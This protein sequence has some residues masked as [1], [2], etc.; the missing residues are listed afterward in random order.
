MTLDEYKKRCAD[1]LAAPRSTVPL[2]KGAEDL[3]DLD[4][5]LAL[6]SLY[7][8]AFK[9]TEAESKECLDHWMSLP[10]DERLKAKVLEDMKKMPKR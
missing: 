7:K 9:G 10:V 1:R 6:F 3:A 4:I 8:L 2:P 5:A